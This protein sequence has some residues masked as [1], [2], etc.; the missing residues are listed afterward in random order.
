MLLTQGWSNKCNM[1]HACVHEVQGHCNLTILY[2]KD[3]KDLGVLEVKL[4]T[5]LRNVCFYKRI[6]PRSG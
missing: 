2:T 5:L 6:H 1:N 4:L 3:L